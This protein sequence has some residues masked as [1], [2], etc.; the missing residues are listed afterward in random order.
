MERREFV[1]KC[2]MSCIGV[3]ASS[4]YLEGCAGTRYITGNLI[5]S[6]LIISEDAFRNEDNSYSKHIVVQS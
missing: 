6:D 5:G 4:I 1:K 2:G 3:M